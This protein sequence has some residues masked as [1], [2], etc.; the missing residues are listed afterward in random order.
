VKPGRYVLLAV[1]D[2]GSGMSPEVKEKIFDPFFTTK[3]KG[4]G[5]G[6]G[7]STVYG[8]VKQSGGYIWVYSELNQGTTFKIYLPWVDGEADN[9]SCQEKTDDFPRGDETILLVEDE[10]SLRSLAAKV[11]RDQGFT[12]LEAAN[13]D[14]AMRLACK[15]T[16]QKIHLVLTDLVMPQ[17]GGKEL[18]EQFK[19]HHPDPRILF[20]SGYTD[21]VMIHQASLEPGTPFLQKPFSPMELVQ[22]VREVLDQKPL[23]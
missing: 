1:T 3:E 2:T 8:I 20:I 12:V 16:H 15:L 23:S 14:E 11:L 17:M 21:G 22:K 6:L 19:R 5:T 13:G 9:L 18:V 7:L 10:D 4:K